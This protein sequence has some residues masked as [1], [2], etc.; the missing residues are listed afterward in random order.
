MPLAWHETYWGF[1]SPPAY[2]NV[3]VP[4]ATRT[5]YISHETTFHTTYSSQIATASKTATYK[6][7]NGKTVTGPNTAK[8]KFSSGSGSTTSKGGG[9]LR[10][11]STGGTSGGSKT[12]GGTSGGAKTSTGGTS[13]GSLR[14][15]HK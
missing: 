13:G 7:S 15:G 9:S 11:G 2:Y 5:V 1:Y 4:A 6:G 14:G 8:L 10:Q 12:T 3:Y